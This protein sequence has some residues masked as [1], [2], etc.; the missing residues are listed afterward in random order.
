V[1]I[2]KW[3]EVHIKKHPEDEKLVALNKFPVDGDESVKRDFDDKMAAI[4]GE[5]TKAVR[6]ICTRRG[7]DVSGPDSRSQSRLRGR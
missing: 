7:C 3:L 2:L 5:L 1:D 4:K 6:G